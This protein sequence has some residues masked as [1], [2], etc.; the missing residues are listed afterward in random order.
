MTIVIKSGAVDLNGINVLYDNVLAQGVFTH[1][2]QSEGFN[3]VN[4][5]EDETWNSWKPA[6]VPA[7]LKVDVGYPVSCDAIGIA[8]HTMFTTGTT[9]RV[10]YSTNDVSWTV[11]FSNY[12]PTSNEDVVGFFPA[13]T[14]R[15]WRVWITG[16][17]SNFGVIKLGKKLAFPNA[18]LSGH[19]PLHHARKFEMI[20]NDSLGG[21]FLG[22]RVV[23]SGA[24]TSINVGQVD[25]DFAET[26]LEDFE[27]HFNTGQ[28]FFY[29]GSPIDTPKDF[30]YCKRPGNG[31][32]MNISWVEGDILADVSFSVVSYVAT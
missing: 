14:A 22:T 2:T 3:A 18:P 8:A 17:I 20:S 16:A 4:A 1:S 26:D 31:G 29:C 23:R 5:N 19:K 10:E 6:V 9:F 11:A 28:A 24:E 27:Y 21:N 30:G 7:S 15:Y 25:R 13:V 32:E 12:T